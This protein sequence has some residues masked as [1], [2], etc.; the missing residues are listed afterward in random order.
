MSYGTLADIISKIRRLTGSANDFQLT[1]AMIQDYI[2]SFYLFDFPAQFRS[3]KLKDK[4][5]FNTIQGVDVYSF[6]SEHYT[7]V[8]MPCYVEKQLVQLFQNPNQFYGN[9]GFNNGSGVQ[10]EDN[11]SAGNNTTGPYSGTLTSTPLVRSVNT[12]PVLNPNHIGIVQNILITANTATGTRNVYDD[13]LG[14]LIGDVLN[15]PVPV[16]P[17]SSGTINYQTGI[18]SGLLFDQIIPSGNQIQCQYIPVALNTPQ[19]ILFFQN[20]FTLRPVPDIGYTVELIA[21]RRPSQ[22]LA[23][24]NS[25]YPEL[26]EWWETIAFG[27]AKKIYEDRLDPDGV[28]LMD[29][30]L[31]ERYSLNETRTYAQLGKQRAGTIFAGQLDNQGGYSG[32]SGLGS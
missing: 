24:A 7:T 25:F 2:D 17:G 19:A 14:N 26:T 8:E 22:A 32:G 20:Q 31:K 12:N 5:V 27:A 28:A 3:L 10:F 13:G 11:F 30:S 16:V 1:N 9:W 15:G 29:K 23:N 6:D 18:I 4:Y 21:Y